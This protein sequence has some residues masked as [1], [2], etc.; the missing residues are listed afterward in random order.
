ER[1]T[2]QLVNRAEADMVAGIETS[3]HAYVTSQRIVIGF[4]LGSIVLA[5]ML[6]YAISSSLIGPV[7]EIESQLNHVAAGDFNKRVQVANRDELGA[8]ASNVNLMCAELDR[9][10]QQ[11]EAASRHK[12]QFLANMSHELRTP[13]NAILGYVELMRDGLY[14][15]LPSKVS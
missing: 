6:G 3:K 12:S 13:L 11:L 10:Y 8:L 4:A 14:G 1:L 7:M 9:L 15:E 5:L 2:N